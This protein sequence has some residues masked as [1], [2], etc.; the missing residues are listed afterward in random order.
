MNQ[1]YLLCIA[2]DVY[3]TETGQLKTYDLADNKKETVELP[4]EFISLDPIKVQQLFDDSG[5]LGTTY[6]FCL[7]DRHSAIS[8]AND[9]DQLI[10]AREDGKQVYAAAY[11]V[12]DNIGAAGQSWYY[13]QHEIYQDHWF[14]PALTYGVPRWYDIEDDLQAWHYME[15]SELKKRKFGYARKIL[16]IP[17]FTDDTVEEV[18]KGITDVLATNDNSIPIICT[19]PPMQGVAEMHA[20]VLDLMSDAATDML[21]SK[22]D[23]RNRICAF[24][25]VP[26]LFAGDVEASGGMNNESQ[27]ITIFDRYLMSPMSY[28]DKLC[29]W[30]MSWW[31]NYITDWQLRLDRPTKAM[32]DAK[33]R[34][35]KIQECQMMLQ[36][37]FEVEQIDGEFYYSKE[38]MQQ[39]DR[40]EQ[41]A[42]QAQM[43][44]AQMMQQAMGDGSGR[45]PGD[46]SEGPP[47]KG[48]ARRDDPDIEESKE[49]VESSMREMM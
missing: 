26:N 47:E 21:A 44:Q 30:I 13:M 31:V 11:K 35:D 1:A 23:I 19:P 9:M 6:G 17:G 3:D 42:Q 41:K 16:V 34:I 43:M 14:S 32:A 7:D 39:V 18:T 37:G 45:M 28:I 5:K 12:G 33:K 25:G 27:Q 20:Q 22:D 48:S 24:I 8:I 38:P 46:G 36:I 4:V 29:D 49:E 10:Q 40:R 15:K 2:R